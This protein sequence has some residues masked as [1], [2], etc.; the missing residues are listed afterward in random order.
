MIL[1]L[2]SL[3]LGGM[4]FD[5]AGSATVN[6]YILQPNNLA[7]MRVG[8]PLPLDAVSD[9]FV[10]ERLI[11]KFISEYFYVIPDAV[12][13][14]ARGGAHSVM[15]AMSSGAVFADWKKNVLPEL[16]S[17]ANRHV[18]RRVAV[19]DILPLDEYWAVG[20]D[21]TTWDSPNILGVEPVTTR[22][23]M[24]L[25]I[26][27][28]NGIRDEINGEVFD[29]GRYLERGGDPAVIFKFKVRKVVK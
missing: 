26:D 29:A 16:E 8:T 1:T 6:G 9:K 23:I 25:Q 15:A 18:L 13:V 2:V 12:D 24:Y 3:F 4:I 19:R 28:E 17:L 22:G 14:A 27:F 10:R 21:L 20:Y 11:K 7:D 5:V